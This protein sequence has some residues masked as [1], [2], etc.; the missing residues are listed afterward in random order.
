MKLDKKLIAILVVALIIA[1]YG[2]GVILT[3][4]MKS[5]SV[6]PLFFEMAGE[7]A[8]PLKGESVKLYKPAV[9]TVTTTATTTPETGDYELPP[10]RMLVRTASLRMESED[11]EEAANRIVM[12]VESYGGYVAQLSVS[13][14]GGSSAHLL[15]K[16]PEKYFFQ[17]LNE[18]KGVGEVVS[19]EVNARDVT[20]HYIDLEARLRNLRAEEEW[21][22]KTMEKAKSVEELMMVEKELWRIRGEIERLEAQMKNLERMVQYSSISITITKPSKP[23]PPPSPYPE[24]DFTPVLVAALT[25][26]I[27]IAYGL[28]FLIIVGIPLG[29]IAYVGY[30]AYRKIFRRKSG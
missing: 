23:A 5:V 3:S 17:A 1:S 21:L 4:F 26:L 19:E 20:E 30:L 25:A 13:S 22:L 6:A 10:G 7:S 28:V 27:Y 18:I 12:I 15:V 24:I 8:A 29:A 11:P 9:R 16:V 14:K 2:V